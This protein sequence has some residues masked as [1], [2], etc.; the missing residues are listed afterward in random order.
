MMRH[1]E[2]IARRTAFHRAYGGKNNFI[3]P[4]IES[5]RT[6]HGGYHYEISTGTGMGGEKLYGFTV[7]SPDGK[8]CENLNACCSSMEEVEYHIMLL[9]TYY[10]EG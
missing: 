6:H 4:N 9:P 1:D 3:T 7:V 2:P 5:R 10:N 8:K